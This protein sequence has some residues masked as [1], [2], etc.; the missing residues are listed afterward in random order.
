MAVDE[1]VGD[2][3]GGAASVESC[4]SYDFFKILAKVSGFDQGSDPG[5]TPWRRPMSMSTT[6]AAATSASMN[7]RWLVRIH[8]RNAAIRILSEMADSQTADL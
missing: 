2:W 3:R 1:R 6:L 8:P 4:H 7:G 5:R